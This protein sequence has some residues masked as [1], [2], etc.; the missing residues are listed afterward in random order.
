MNLLNSYNHAI[1]HNNIYKYNVSM[2][3]S[4]CCIDHEDLPADNCQT[5]G[6]LSKQLHSGLTLTAAAGH[7]F[8]L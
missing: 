8:I 7:C 5:L 3:V 4:C 6:R 2:N 1:V